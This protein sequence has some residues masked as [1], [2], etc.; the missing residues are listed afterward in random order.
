MKISCFLL[1][2][3]SLLL[4]FLGSFAVNTNNPVNSAINGV[5]GSVAS[6]LCSSASSYIGN[7]VLSASNGITDTVQ[8]IEFRENERLQQE[9][10]QHLQQENEPENLNN[11]CRV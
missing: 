11:F 2:T 6:D 5:L 1:H 3:L 7:A 4:L 9:I 10:N 8:R